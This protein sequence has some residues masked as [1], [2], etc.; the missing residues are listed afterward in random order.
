MKMQR[1]DV[2][3]QQRGSRRMNREVGLAVR[4]L[5]CIKQTVGTH[6]RAQG[7]RLVLC[8]DLEGW[9]V[10]GGRLQREGIHVHIYLIYSIK[11]QKLTQH[12]EATI[13]KVK[14][15]QSR[16][17]LCNPMDHTAQILQNTEVVAVPFSRGLPNPGIEPR[18]PTLQA[19]SLPAEPPGKPSN[20]I[21][22][23]NQLPQATVINCQKFSVL[24]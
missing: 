9:D 16:S 4:A 21:V 6:R 12:Y 20:D 22:M 24:K 1:V 2:W 23:L 10:E 8:D 19:D 15:A 17:T 13:V 5:P 11:Q 3:A 7:G 14:V 18:P